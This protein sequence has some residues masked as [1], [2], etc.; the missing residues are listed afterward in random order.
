MDTTFSL[1]KTPEDVAKEQEAARRAKALKFANHVY[2]KYKNRSGLERVWQEAAATYDSENEK[3]VYEGVANIATSDTNT[4]ANS[5]VTFCAEKMFGQKPYFSLTGIGG[6]K[7]NERAAINQKIIEMQ[8]D[9]IQFE[10]KFRN[11]LTDMVIYGF[12]IAKVPY[13]VKAKYVLNPVDKMNAAEIAALQMSGVDINQPQKTKKI[14]YDNIDFIPLNRFNVF[15]NPF[16]PWAE[17]PAIVEIFNELPLSKIK[18]MIQVDPDRYLPDAMEIIMS[19]PTLKTGFSGM[20]ETATKKNQEMPHLSNIIGIDDDFNIYEKTHQLM[21]CWCSYDIDGDGLDEECVITVFDQW[22]VI[23]LE[24]N[25]YWHGEK[26]YLMGKWERMG[27]AEAVGKGG[28]QKARPYQLMLNDFTNQLMDNIT[29]NLTP[30]WIVARQSGLALQQLKSRPNGVIMPANVNDITPLRPNDTTQAAIYGIRLMK[31]NIHEATGATA[32][33]QGLPARYDTSA[34]EAQNMRNSSEAGIFNKLADLEQTV[35]MP[36][37]RIAY[38]CNR[39]Y[40]TRD[41]VIKII[42][43]EALTAFLENFGGGRTLEDEWELRDVVLGDYDFAPKGI[44]EQ[45][46]K[47][48]KAQMTMNLFN[49]ALRT[50]PGIWNLRT[51]AKRIVEDVADGD[52]SLLAPDIDDTLLSPADE[53]VLMTQGE[54]VNA[55]EIENHEAHIQIHLQAKNGIMPEFLPLVETHIQQHDLF[56]QQQQRAMQLMAMSGGFGAGT[57]NGSGGNKPPPIPSIYGPSQMNERRAA[58]VPGMFGAP[59]GGGQSTNMVG[60]GN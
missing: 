21:E 42:G 55:K 5:L 27:N 11:F 46:N 45:M 40:M 53:N 19:S 28:V 6:A 20:P 49:T 23:R 26:P 7:D 41:D 48:V 30:M 29:M 8:M 4:A 37:L 2:T 24:Y 47:T 39:Q 54:A 32:S 22:K 44:K 52:T 12:A 34:T 56:L 16:V 18:M 35:L 36:F 33:L 25:P 50:P 15:W 60:G 1:A 13:V 9:K 10:S 51:L 17:Q 58:Q 38:S 59:P 43:R 31:E 14:V 57:G 3:R